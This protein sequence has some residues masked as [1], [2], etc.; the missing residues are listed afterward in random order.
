VTTDDSGIAIADDDQPIVHSV[1]S[2]HTIKQDTQPPY[3]A[4]G[5]VRGL[6]PFEPALNNTDAVVVFRRLRRS[7][8]PW[9]N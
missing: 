4:V 3:G 2:P 8:L 9:S 5:P 7:R 1:A 6:F